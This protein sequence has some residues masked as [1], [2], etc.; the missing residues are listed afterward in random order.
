MC[1]LFRSINFVLCFIAR[2]SYFSPPSTPLL[3]FLAVGRIVCEHCE[4]RP[5]SPELL[6]V[7]AGCVWRWPTVWSPAPA[8]PA[9]ECWK[10]KGN[11]DPVLQRGQCGGRATSRLQGQEAPP[12]Q[13]RARRQ[14]TGALRWEERAGKPSMGAAGGG[15]ARGPGSRGV[16]SRQL[17]TFS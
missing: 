9:P 10:W 1:D 8:G 7:N 4:D 15:R 14:H 11:L 16:A 6:E 17:P 13:H 2:G 5:S 12:P 3:S